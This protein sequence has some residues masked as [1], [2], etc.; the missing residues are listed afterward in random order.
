M[1]KEFAI[2]KNYIFQFQYVKIKI[3]TTTVIKSDSKYSKSEGNTCIA[4][5]VKSGGITLNTD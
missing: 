5:P 4:K 3:S 2:D 1:T